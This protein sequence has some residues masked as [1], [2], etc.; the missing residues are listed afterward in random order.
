M[1]AKKLVRKIAGL[2]VAIP[3]AVKVYALAPF[4]GKEKAIVFW[5]PGVTAMAKRSLRYWVPQIK[6]AAEFDSFPSRIKARFRL[7][8][9]FFDLSVVQEDH[10]TFRIHVQNCPFC[11]AFNSLGMSQMGPYL[12][13]GDWEV[14]KE[15]SDKW[16]FHRKHQIGTGDSYCDHTYFRRKH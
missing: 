4:I 11:E 2:T 7:W 12:C 3:T 9:P 14:A 6:T 10:D 1:K 16:G 5:G 15:H 13:Q 8:R